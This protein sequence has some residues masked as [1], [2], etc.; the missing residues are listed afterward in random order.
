MG[1]SGLLAPRDGDPGGGAVADPAPPSPSPSLPPPLPLPGPASVDGVWEALVQRRAAEQDTSPA[2]AV[3]PERTL[4]GYAPTA[5]IDGCWL[6]AAVHVRYAHSALGAA[7]IDAFYLE[8]GEGDAGRHH[9]NL[10]RALLASAGLSL[11]EPASAALA[12]EPRLDEADFALALSGLQLAR[13]RG[14]PDLSVIVG[15]H[16]AATILGPPP[17]VVRAAVGPGLFLAAHDAASP[18]GQRAEQLARRCLSAWAEQGGADWQALW[19][20]A[21]RLIEQRQAWL[22]SLHPAVERSPWQAMIELVE[23]KARHGFGYHRQLALGGRRFDEWL[24]PQGA[25]RPDA[26]GFLRELARSRWVVPGQPDR[27][28][29][30]QR[31][32]AFGGPMFGVFTD[33]ELAVM[34]AWIT[35]LGSLPE[36]ESEGEV[37]TEDA[38][39]RDPPPSLLPLRTVPPAPVR[40]A[41]PSLPLLYHRLLSRGGEP[42]TAALARE[43][44]TRVLAH[45]ARAVTPARLRAQGLWPYDAPRLQGWVEARLHEQL[46]DGKK[47]EELDAEPDTTGLVPELV[48]DDVVFL[49]TQIAPAA[50]VDGA[51]LHG[52]ASPASFHTPVSSLLFRIYRDELGAG[53]AYQHH[54]NVLRRALAA[55]GV[56]LPA[57]DSAE[58]AASSGLLP[59]AFS[60]PVLW[61]CAALHGDEFLPELLGLNLAIEM[62]GVGRT[63]E[64][65]I[66]LLRRHGIDAYYF[67]LHNTIDNGATGH[68]AWST[69]AIRLYFDEQLPRGD[70]AAR[71]QAWL[72]LWRGHAAYGISSGPLLRAVALRLGPRLGWRWL[73][74]QIIG[75]SPTQPAARG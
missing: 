10:Y 29:L 50:L 71:E 52:A 54:G 14:A 19:R 75:H 13:P 43:H 35:A 17:C 5:L 33:D 32:V 49:L 27:S 42:E 70:A 31:A 40:G 74:R 7:L 46:F 45:A 39:R 72:R 55:Q 20:G 48:H 60:T 73:R 15:F 30:T 66:R 4:L 68:T 25:Q 22:A 9:G 6:A 8:S 69:Q 16:V 34:R 37:A 38:P 56:D 41:A 3:P 18:S 51:W 11:P 53:V 23:S 1:P 12:E 36:G 28:P 65:A 63:Y 21:A 26:R 58:F 44:I 24:D 47:P 62:A 64:R 59:A 61:L 2:G 57:C 67:E